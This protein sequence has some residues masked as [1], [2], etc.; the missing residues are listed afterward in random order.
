MNNK[1][2]IILI[3]LLASQFI[4]PSQV[5]AQGSSFVIS[6]S[7]GNFSV[8]QIVQASVLVQPNGNEVNAVAGTLQ[9]PDD[10]LEVVNVSKGSVFNFWQTSPSGRNGSIV[11]ATGR[12][13]SVNSSSNVFNVSFKVK[14][15][16]TANIVVL[17]SSILLADGEGTEIATSPHGATWNLKV[18]ESKP[19][20]G[21]PEIFSTTNPNSENWY[22]V[23]TPELNWKLPKN[24][25]Q[26]LTK[27]DLDINGK[28]TEKSNPTSNYFVQNLADGSYYF[29]LAF[30]NQNGQGP[31]RTFK[32][33]KDTTPPQFKLFHSHEGDVTVQKYLGFDIVAEDS[34]SGISSY[35]VKINNDD[36]LT[37]EP[38][39]EKTFLLPKLDI[40]R[41]NL[42]FKITDKAG[43]KVERN[44]SIEIV[45][46][47][48]IIPWYIWLIICLLVLIIILM[49]KRQKNSRGTRAQSKNKS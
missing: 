15:S 49:S 24:L 16:G 20:P 37:L 40:G 33:N 1:I 28:P 41:Q 30:V 14:N 44:Y 23:E 43:N 21:I 17:N 29:H 19:L 2:K 38:F 4:S 34:L 5:L 45:P 11:F 8:G 18:N 25:T 31:T 36:W 39:S 12:T 35:E 6:P 42:I 26:I 47:V 10:L 7:S 3:F 27:V 48:S 9:Y 22:S 32:F 46:E 13:G